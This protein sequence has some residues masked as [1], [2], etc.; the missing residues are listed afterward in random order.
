M[1][2]KPKS[3]V[4]NPRALLYRRYTDLEK[5]LSAVTVYETIDNKVW[6]FDGLEHSFIELDSTPSGA[7]IVEITSNEQ[8]LTYKN[9]FY[10]YTADNG[11]VGTETQPTGTLASALQRG[12]IAKYQLNKYYLVGSFDYMVKG[13]IE[14]TDGQPIKGLIT[15]TT[16]L[17]IRTYTDTLKLDHDDLVV[18]DGRLYS[19]ESIEISVLRM[20][21]KYNIYYATLNNIL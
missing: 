15:P 14:T 17:T 6:T 4:L 8:Y 20:P 19:V 10:T 1:R 18:L 16:S 9:K 12:T 13:T 5:S 3:S 2:L 21:K 11:W 7:T